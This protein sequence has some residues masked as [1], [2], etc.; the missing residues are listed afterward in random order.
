MA[1]KAAAIRPDEI[2][3]IL[4][5]HLHGDHFGGIPFFVLDAQL[6]SKRTR[7]L[8]VVGPPGTAT[9][10][11]E[12]MEVLFPGS[13]RVRRRFALEVRE[14]PERE[15]L[16]LG[17][18][19]VTG[20]PVVHFSGAAS[21]AVRVEWGGRV[22]TYSG[23]TEW[24]PALIEA[25]ADA[26]LFVCEA[27]YFDKVMKFHLDYR[28]L[29]EHRQDFRCGRILLTHMNEDLLRRLDEVE[30]ETAFDGLRLQL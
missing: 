24:T 2:A 28:T 29:R 27:Y 25:A 21:Y 9:R 18:L 8:V 19:A 15:R 7:P 14:L 30:M 10:L 6:V 23:D 4:V 17:S 12:T 11:E 5:S 3:T 20:F 13:S 26:D 16:E 22:I 1:L